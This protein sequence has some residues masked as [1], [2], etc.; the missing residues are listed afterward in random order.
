MVTKSVDIASAKSPAITKRRELVNVIKSL[1]STRSTIRPIG[2]ANRSHGNITNAASMEIKTGF[3]VNE[4]AKSGA[5]TAKSP[6]AKLLITLAVKRRLNPGPNFSAV[7]LSTHGVPST[8]NHF[9]G[10]IRP[11]SSFK[12]W[13]DSIRIF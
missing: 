5:A 6:S 3:L 9:L 1:L 11:P 10:F 7:N 2:I 13:V 12:V 8:R 4:I